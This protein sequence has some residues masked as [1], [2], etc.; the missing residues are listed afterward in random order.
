LGAGAKADADA[1]H[2]A[3]IRAEVFILQILFFEQNV[4]VMILPV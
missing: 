3:M 1:T 2:P 4:K